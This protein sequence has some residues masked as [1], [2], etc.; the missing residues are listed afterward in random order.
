M[1]DGENKRYTYL[2][3]GI[4]S[5]LKIPFSFLLL[6]CII[7]TKCVIFWKVFLCFLHFK[8]LNLLICST[9]YVCAVLSFILE[10]ISTGCT[11]G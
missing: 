3:N 11:L 5:S 2:L 9:F 6:D 10:A 4:L 8:N 1:S 7:I